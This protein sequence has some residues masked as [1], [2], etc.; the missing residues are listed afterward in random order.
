M[1]NTR[2]MLLRDIIVVTCLFFGATVSHADVQISLTA[3]GVDLDHLQVGVPATI[4]VQ[5]SG[6]EA[7]Q[8][9]DTLAATV[10]YD[11]TL[12]GIPS[13]SSGPI[14]P[15][16]L[17]SPRDFLPDEESGMADATF[18]TFGIE[19]SNHITL[20][21]TFFSFDVTTLVTGSGS[22]VFDFADAME[23]NPADPYNPIPLVLQKGPALNFIVIP[24]PAGGVLILAL[25]AGLCMRWLAK[26]LRC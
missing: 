7:G 20:E 4:L 18:M 3:P 2:R 17:N 11:G 12:L 26:R 9:L 15:N 21:G 23:F 6:L 8:E 13:I 5:L 16:P 10:L 1:I 14:V 25:T 19:S 24:E 22:L